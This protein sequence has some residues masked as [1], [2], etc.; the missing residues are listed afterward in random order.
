MRL[1]LKYALPLAQM[2]LAVGLLRCSH[3]WFMAQAKISD[4]PGPAPA[5]TLLVSINA[6]VAMA[7]AF[8]YRHLPPAWDEVTFI[9]AIG[10]LWYWVAS[11][12]LRWKERR[13]LVMFAWPPLRIFGD[14]LMIANGAF[15]GWLYIVHGLG[16]L[17]WRWFVPS[18]AFFAMWSLSLIVFFTVDIIRC[19]HAVTH[20]ISDTA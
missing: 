3:F 18:S 15:L 4:M 20:R 10:L 6:P 19:I 14:L 16:F 12:I 11:S 13:S 7:R 8:L 9:L 2:I 5:F 17:T 1:K